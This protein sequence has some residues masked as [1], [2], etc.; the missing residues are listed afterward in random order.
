[1]EKKKK[2]IKNCGLFLDNPVTESASYIC[3]VN[4]LQG[5]VLLALNG[6]EL[7]KGKRMP[8]AQIF[9]GVR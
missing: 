1:M 9:L 8:S 6:V 7:S 2:I 5:I 4:C 3:R